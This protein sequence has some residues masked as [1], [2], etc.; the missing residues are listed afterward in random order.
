MPHGVQ[1]KDEDVRLDGVV[2]PLYLFLERLGS[3]HPVVFGLP[4][5]VTSGIDSLHVA[6]SKHKS[7]HAVDVRIE[8]KAPEDQ[9]IFLL[10]CRKLAAQ[11]GLCLFDETNLVAGPHLHVETQG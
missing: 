11:F 9:P 2:Y 10:I 3:I 5:V 8:D 4:V 6:S 1:A 7:G